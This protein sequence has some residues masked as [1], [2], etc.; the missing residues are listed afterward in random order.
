MAAR[1]PQSATSLPWRINA[2]WAARGLQFIAWPAS[3]DSCHVLLAGDAATRIVPRATSGAAFDATTGRITGNS[4]ID[5]TFSV[6]G[7]IGAMTE[8][9]YSYFGFSHYGSFPNGKTN[10]ALNLIT[11]NAT[12]GLGISWRAGGS[13]GG[14]YD[15]VGGISNGGNTLL[16]DTTNGT[17]NYTINTQHFVTGAIRYQR[18][19]PIAMQR[20]W[21]TGVEAIVRRTSPAAPSSTTKIGDTGQ[22]LIFGGSYYL[23]A[24]TRLEFECAFDGLAGASTGPSDAD[25]AALTANPSI[26]IEATP[27]PATINLGITNLTTAATLSTAAVTVTPPV[28]GV[29]NLNIASMTS[30]A[31]LSTAA[32]S[33]TPLTGTITSGVFTAYGS[34]APLAG[35]T[36]PRTVVLKASD[37]SLVMNLPN[38]VTNGAGVISIVNSAIVTGNWYMV[39]NWDTAAPLTSRGFKAYLAT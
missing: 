22:P 36:V 12:I 2:Y 3:A 16:R 30:A 4:T 5:F 25:M 17:P 14:Q 7:G 20:I 27:T 18:D 38:L 34:P 29:V 10:P 26:A 8:Q 35:M 6:A 21:Y 28:A 15:I 11:S 39:G 1:F 24:N 33:V 31:T 32:V 19:D 23:D 9:S 37:G 13:A